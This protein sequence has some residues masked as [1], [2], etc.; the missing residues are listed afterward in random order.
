MFDHPPYPPFGINPFLNWTNPPKPFRASRPGQ[1]LNFEQTVPTG[2]QNLASPFQVRDQQP[3]QEAPQYNPISETFHRVFPALT[4]PVPE[5]TPD[6]QG[7]V[8][9][10]RMNFIPRT[11]GEIPDSVA[12][13]P[14]MSDADVRALPKGMYNAMFGSWRPSLVPATIEI[15]NI[16]RRE[17]I[18]KK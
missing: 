8:Y 15:N 2:F 10:K 14:P 12:D 1:V 5:P 18:D 13:L 6:P 16:L 3:T 11:V 17:E 9:P 7:P 4:P